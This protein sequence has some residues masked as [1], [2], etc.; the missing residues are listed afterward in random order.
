[1]GKMI[2][3]LS[4]QT[5]GLDGRFFLSESGKELDIRKKVELI[6]D[7][8]SID[9]NSKDVITGL[10][11]RIALRLESGDGY[12]SFRE[13]VSDLLRVVETISTDVE[14]S[15]SMDELIAQPLLKIISVGIMDPTNIMESITEYVRLVASYSDKELV[16][17]VNLD[18]FMSNADYRNCLRQVRYL[19]TPILF[20]ETKTKDDDIPTKLL[21]ADYCELN[22]GFEHENIFEV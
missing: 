18:L 12:L 3:E 6:I 17:I 11:K 14:S 7:P 2:W 22:F 9:L 20:I 21:D 5:A 4:N 13:A 8:F 1:M 16:V 15:V 19:Q 10:H